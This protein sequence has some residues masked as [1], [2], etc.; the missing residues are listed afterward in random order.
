MKLESEGVTGEGMSF[1]S[2]EKE[3]AQAI[4]YNVKTLIQGNVQDSQIQI[5]SSD[6]TQSQTTNFDIEQLVKLVEALRTT[7]DSIGIEDTD[8]NELESEISTIESQAKSPNPKNSIIG[9]SL[10]SIR[11]ILEGASGNLIASGLLN[12]IGVLFGV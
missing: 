3:L 2:T 1:S 7:I 10:A 11:R 5:E 12:Q 4:T 6:S 8:K 9:E